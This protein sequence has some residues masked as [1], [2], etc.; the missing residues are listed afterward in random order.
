MLYLPVRALSGGAWYLFTQFGFSP[1]AL[2]R[3]KNIPLAD[4][5]WLQ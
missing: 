4:K 1:F 5:F 3:N 2:G